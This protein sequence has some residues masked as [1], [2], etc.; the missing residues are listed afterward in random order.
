MVEEIHM[1]ETKGLAENRIRGNLDGNSA[2]GAS[3][4]NQ[5]QSANNMGADSMLNKQLECSGTGSSAGCGEQLH[6]EQ[7]NQEKRSRTELQVPTS[8]EGSVMNFLP[9]QRN[10]GIDI[11]GLGAVSLTLGL[12]HGVENA[13]QHQHP[14]LQQHEDQLRRQFGGQMIH[15]Y[16]VAG[17]TLIMVLVVEMASLTCG[18]DEEWLSDC[19]KDCMPSC[20]EIKEAT[21]EICQISCDNACRPLT[22]PASLFGG[23]F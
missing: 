19:A 2:E 10:S 17:M 15:D 20:M 8:M 4:Q 11:G 18:Q 7:W 3:Q 14:Q 13:Q 6:A 16:K 9:Y 1:L 12:R 22:K 5:E 21:E 23:L